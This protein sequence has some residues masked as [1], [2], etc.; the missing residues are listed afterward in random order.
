MEKSDKI[1]LTVAIIGT[2][3]LI[4]AAIVTGIFSHDKPTVKKDTTINQ[5]Q[6]GEEQ[7]Q[8]GKVE[9]RGDNPMVFTGTVH[10]NFIIPTPASP[11]G[12]IT[13]LLKDK[14]K[15]KEQDDKIVL[16]RNDIDKLI[17]ALEDLDQRTSGIKRL[18]DGRSKIG[19]IISGTPSIAIESHN[20]AIE[21]LRKK[22]FS[23]AFQ[24]SKHAIEA[25][26]TSQQVISSM[27]TKISISTPNRSTIAKLYY[28][29]ARSA[30]RVKEHTLALKWADKANKT[31]SNL[32][33]LSLYGIALFNLNEQDKALEIINDG[34]KKYP[35]NQDLT[36]LKQ[37]ITARMGNTP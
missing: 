30:N 28:V 7:V 22:D 1:K 35:D 20:K 4:G 27:P 29:G 3:G 36:S 21:F 9:Q 8:I 15:D 33:R 11:T 32:E 16:N 10:Q 24:H 34:L 12:V 2:V 19:E 31:E 5:V 37:N 6:Q 23:T 14:T 13:K 18:P 25:Y 17:K 26:E